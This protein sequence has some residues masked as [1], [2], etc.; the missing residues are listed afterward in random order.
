[1]EAAGDDAR[2]DQTV[3][4]PQSRKHDGAH[5]PGDGRYAHQHAEEGAA[6]ALSVGVAGGDAIKAQ[7]GSVEERQAH[8]RQ[9]DRLLIVGPPSV[10]AGAH[11]P[12]KP[13]QA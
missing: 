12:A 2:V 5:Q 6:Y 9:E 13:P 8:S 4:L 3:R 11:Q 10:L 7:Y 1:M